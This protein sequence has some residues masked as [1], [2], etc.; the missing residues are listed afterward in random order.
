MRRIPAP[1][2]IAG[3]AIFTIL[4]LYLLYQAT[5]GQNVAVLLA[6]ALLFLLGLMALIFA[7][8]NTIWHRHMLRQSP[9][10]RNAEDK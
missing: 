2:E 4:G 1:T 7:V 8:R 3:Y 6:G 10:D 9:A 5:T